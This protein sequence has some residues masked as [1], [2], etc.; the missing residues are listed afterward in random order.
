MSDHHDENHGHGHI[1]L[2]YQP[3]LPM[4]NGKLCLWLF[5]S[6]EIMFFAGLIGAYVVLRFGVPSGTWPTPH[7]V[8]L[9]E[10]TGAF[11]TF[12][13]ICSSLSV[14]LGLEAAKSNQSAQA[15]SWL[16]ITFLLGCV[17]LGVKM[18]EYSGKFAHG[19]YPSANH[20]RMYDKA[21]VYYVSALKVHLEQLQKSL[22]PVAPPEKDKDK[23][24]KDKGNA[25]V[26]VLS[27]ETIKDLETIDILRDGLV[28]WSAKAAALEEN[29]IARRG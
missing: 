21:D 18:Y 2:E 13:L 9:S 14:V 12:V 7:D 19:I 26:P 27:P 8:H 25:P 29:P 23:D 28:L 1:E 24:A 6:T 17:F 20:S 3:A 10:P 4:N 15:K 16:W 5:L 22:K 11:N